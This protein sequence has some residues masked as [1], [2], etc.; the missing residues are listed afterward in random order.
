[1][2]SRSAGGIFSLYFQTDRKSRSCWSFRCT[3]LAIS[4]ALAS[5]S[6]SRNFL[7]PGSALFFFFFFFFF[8]CSVSSSGIPDGSAAGVGSPASSGFAEELPGHA[9]SSGTSRMGTSSFALS[10]LFFFFF[11]FGGIAGSSPVGMAALLS[12]LGSCRGQI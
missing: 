3:F 5:R 2:V 11:L 8:G 9:P 1:M 12:L 10:L 4:L 6:C 7:R